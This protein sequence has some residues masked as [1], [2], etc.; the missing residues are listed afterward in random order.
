MTGFVLGKFYPFHKGHEYLMRAALAHCDALKV[1][2]C[3]AASEH[4]DGELRCA[5]IRETL[6]DCPQVEVLLLEY[7]ERELPNSSA[8]SREISR[9]WA[10][11]LKEIFPTAG[12]IFTSEPY[13]DF[14]AEY[15]GI[16]HI[17]MPEEGG[18]R[19]TNIRQNPHKYWHRIP[20]AVRPHY[21]KKIAILGTESVGKTQLAQ[22]LG[23]HLGAAVAEEAGRALIPDSSRFSMEDLYAVAAAH[24]ENIRRAAGQLLPFVV[25]DTDANITCSYARFAFGQDLA[26]NAGIWAANKADLYLYLRADLAWVQD[27]TRM[28]EA[29]RMRLDQCHRDFLAERGIEFVEIGGYGP[30]RLANAL[31]AIKT[32]FEK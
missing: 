31:A 22:E 21:Q 7:D 11:K 29:D 8:S 19:A 10:A 6:A 18:V 26:L 28:P 2:V 4:I 1:L 12:V 14:V 32:H 20:D 30:Q 3:K 5:W 24:A 27:G 16:R 23:A 17:F 13:G 15:M 25:M 9:V